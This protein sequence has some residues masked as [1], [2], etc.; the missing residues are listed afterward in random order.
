MTAIIH[1]VPCALW[2]T[3]IIKIFSTQ[4]NYYY[5]LIVLII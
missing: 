2:L 5:T 4:Y 3:G 1:V